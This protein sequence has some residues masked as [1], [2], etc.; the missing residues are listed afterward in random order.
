[1]VYGIGFTTLLLQVYVLL[2]LVVSTP[3]KN[4]SQLGLFFPI[5]GKI[6]KI[7][8]TTNHVLCLYSA[9]AAGRQ[10]FSAQVAAIRCTGKRC[11]A[12]G[13]SQGVPKEESLGT[14]TVGCPSTQL[15][16][17]KIGILNHKIYCLSQHTK[18]LFFPT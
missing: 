10:T 7:V 3:L 13:F 8:Q 14:R 12:P 1:M 18:Y 17:P 2:W 6:K 9:T 16:P 4:I 15:E 5:S 11:S